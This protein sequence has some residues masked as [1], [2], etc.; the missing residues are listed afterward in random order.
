MS[1]DPTIGELRDLLNNAREF[2]ADDE[3]P[4][5]VKNHPS[6]S[7][8]EAEYTTVEIRTGDRDA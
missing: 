6:G 2:G 1:R 4:V 5:E 7:P 3:T 8:V